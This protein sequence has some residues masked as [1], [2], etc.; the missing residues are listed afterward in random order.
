[1][2]AS[3]RDRW[4]S[5]LEYNQSVMNLVPQFWLFEVGIHAREGVLHGMTQ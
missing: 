4:R 3:S 1:M 2:P 5:V